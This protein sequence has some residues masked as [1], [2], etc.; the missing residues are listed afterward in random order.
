MP[1]PREHKARMRQRILAAA[2]RLFTAQGFAPTSIEQVMAESGLTRGAFYAYFRSKAELYQQAVQA[3]TPPAD[4]AGLLADIRAALAAAGAAAQPL[5]FLAR[6]LGH[7]A[8][9]VRAAYA[10]AL[11]ALARRVRLACDTPDDAGALPLAAMVV[12]LLGIA[13]TL[14]DAALRARLVDACLQRL[15]A[16]DTPPAQAEPTS[17]FWTVEPPPAHAARLH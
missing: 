11:Q 3:R 7:S 1:Y 2:A 17:F 10:Q 8:P 5:G 4:G 6:D 12:G 13:Q 9:E 14:D 16:P 15:A